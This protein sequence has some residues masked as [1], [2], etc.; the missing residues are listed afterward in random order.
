M[1]HHHEDCP[2]GP[3]LAGLQFGEQFAVW[4]I[5][6]WVAAVKERRSP[7]GLLDEGFGVAGCE[8]A[9]APLHAF[10]RILAVAAERPIDVR[11]IHCRHVSPDETSFLRAIAGFQRG[12]YGEGAL[13]IAGYL[14]PAAARAAIDHAAALASRLAAAGLILTGPPPR[15]AGAAVMSRTLH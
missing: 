7:G 8:D 1:A 2:G 9:L 5:R 10:M 4:A 14:R 6:V 11:C 3:E 15:T 12:S 13:L